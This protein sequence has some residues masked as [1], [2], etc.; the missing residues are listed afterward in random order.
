MH[1]IGQYNT[2]D[3]RQTP[4]TSFL[5]FFLI[6]S[7]PV[8]P[9]LEN[10]LIRLAG[11]LHHIGRKCVHFSRFAV[12]Q[13]A[14][15]HIHRIQHNMH[16]VMRGIHISRMHRPDQLVAVFEVRRNRRCII[17]GK[18]PIIRSL[19]KGNY[20][21]SSRICTELIVISPQSNHLRISSILNIGIQSISSASDLMIPSIVAYIPRIW[22]MSPA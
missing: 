12:E 8:R 16:I 4:G 18:R 17:D 20:N 22:H 13:T 1:Y 10:E 15:L 14:V 5:Q 21:V 11:E 2:N 3:A 7:L 19:I 6:R 9:L